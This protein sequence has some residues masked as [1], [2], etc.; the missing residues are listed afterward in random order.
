L[1]E[2]NGVV[3]DLVPPAVL[4]GFVRINGPLHRWPRLDSR[5]PDSNTVVASSPTKV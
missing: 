5:A 3:V 2:Q 4:L 1:I